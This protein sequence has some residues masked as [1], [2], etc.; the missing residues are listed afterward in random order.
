MTLFG[1]VS[2]ALPT[3]LLWRPS[4]PI[5]Q[6]RTPGLYRCV[7]A[8]I[9]TSAPHCVNDPQGMCRHLHVSALH[10]PSLPQRRADHDPSARRRVRGMGR[11]GLAARGE[12]SPMSLSS[13]ILFDEAFVMC[14]LCLRYVL[15]KNRHS[16]GEV[17]C[18]SVDEHVSLPSNAKLSVRFNSQASAQGFFSIKKL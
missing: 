6:T 14:N 7:C 12:V 8:A 9:L 5:V 16:A 3:S 18:L 11:V 15:R 10:A 1:Q 13:L 2:N 4:S 17:T